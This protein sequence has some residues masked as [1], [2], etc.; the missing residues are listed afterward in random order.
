[1]SV[2]TRVTVTFP[3]EVLI[4]IDRGDRNRSQFILEVVHR[5]IAGLL[6]N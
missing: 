1:M 6:S 4:E 3:S 2:S 5:E